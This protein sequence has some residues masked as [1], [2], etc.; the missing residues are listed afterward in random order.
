M[1]L[2]RARL[3]GGRGDEARRPVA[4]CGGE[5]VA[6]K[7]DAGDVRAGAERAADPR[8]QRQGV[9]RGGTETRKR[10]GRAHAAQAGE[11]RLDPLARQI[12]ADEDEAA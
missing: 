12:L 5:R 1:H 7:G 8:D 11:P 6:E 2:H 3:C 4:E 10:T 9:G